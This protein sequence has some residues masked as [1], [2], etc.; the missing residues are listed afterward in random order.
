MPP[1]KKTYEFRVEAG[2]RGERIDRFLARKLPDF[3]RSYIQKLIEK[4]LVRVD[5]RTVKP[6]FK[7]EANQ[8]IV[9]E[10][11]PPEETEIK[12]QPIPLDV[13]YEDDHLL[14][15]HKPAGLV[16]HPGAGVREGTLVNALMYHCRDLS[17]VGGR[18]RP[19][20]VHRLDKNTSGL[21]VVAKDDRT[22]LGLQKQFAEKTARRE[23]RALVWGRL[24]EPSGRIETLVGRSP[25][26][27]KK[28]TV[29]REGKL[30]ITLY[31]VER[32]Y[33][34]LTL[35]RVQ[36]KTGRSHQIRIHFKHI[37]H[38]VFG[39]P[40]YGGR[41]KQ[42]N[43]LTHLSEKRL[44]QQLLKIMPRQAL[45]AYK[46]GFVHPITGKSMVFEIDLPEDFQQVL[47]VLEAHSA[48]EEEKEFS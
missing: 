21:L 6:S 23:Y 42:L 37:H 15:I 44:A 47:A 40:E 29:T 7:L 16:V 38:P 12:P 36:L 35:V 22:H 26:D 11:P 31:Q 28:F 43:R 10:I 34:F 1:P 39:D 2:D 48:T 46:L 14:V 32:Y 45:H 30:A 18:L 25:G 3:S 20:I 4:Q 13:V 33:A 27:R 5:T 19:G 24:K 17:G 41:N 8:H 9:V